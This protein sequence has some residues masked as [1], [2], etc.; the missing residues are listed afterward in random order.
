M[1]SIIDN[2]PEIS[3]IDETQVTEVLNQMIAD[4]QEKYKEKTG[5]EAVL[6]QSDPIRLVMYACTLQIYQAMQ[7][8][9]FAG[10]MNFLKYSIGDY[11]D[12]LGAQRGVM[13][14]QA[15]P[16]TTILEFSMP[17]TLSSAVTIA[18]GTRVTNGNEVYFSTDKVA[19]IPAGSTSVTV[20][21][22]CMTPGTSGN[23]FAPGELSTLVETHP[24]ITDVENTTE[25][26]GG[27]DIETDDELRERIFGAPGAYSVAGPADAYEYFVKEADPTITDVKVY[28][29]D[30]G[31]VD[32]CIV[33]NG[34]EI[35]SEDLLDKVETYLEESSVRPLTDYVVLH[36]PTTQT[37]NISLTYYIARSN[38][39]AAASIQSA[40]NT[41]V[42]AYNA[43]QT[44]KLGRDINP[45]YLIQK[46]M[47]A[48]AK[49]VVV[50]A[51]TQTTLEATQLAVLG[52]QTVTYG[53][54]EDD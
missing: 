34:N 49:R 18:A 28:S 23:G 21:A 13:R 44:E 4:Y 20:S 19:E 36:A 12:N 46:I 5:K 24:Y 37:Y 29:S 3:F 50:T 41:A 17:S 2:F 48:G 11:L 43:W 9:D 16:A 32:I 38:S 27:A 35:P 22:T 30:P 54:L 39:N 47:E 40:V 26:E 53:G 51:P 33:V 52:T 6:A 8:A 15:R 25:T 1:S 42:A 10:K 7:Y 45:S 14:K 31:Q